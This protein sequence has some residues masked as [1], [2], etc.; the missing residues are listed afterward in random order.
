M[1]SIQGNEAAGSLLRF[2][3]DDRVFSFNLASGATFGEIARKMGEV[4]NRHFGKP[5]AIDVTLGRA[6]T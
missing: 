3:F 6:E 1:T 2:V 4:Q 5:V